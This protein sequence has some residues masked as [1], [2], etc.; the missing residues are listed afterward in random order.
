L[1][2]LP[3]PEHFPKNSFISENGDIIKLSNSH[4]VKYSRYSGKFYSLTTTRGCPFSCAYCCNSFYNKLYGKPIIR[5]RSVEN[6]IQEL[7][8]AI[9]KFPDFVYINIQ[10]DNFFTYDIDWMT[11]F[12]NRYKKE[13]G[14]NFVCRTNP[15]LLN[16]E[17]ISVLRMT[18][19]SWIFMGLQ[20]GSARI[21]KEIYKR[22]VSNKKFIEATKIIHKHNIAGYYDVI[23]DNPY[24][25]DRDL[26]RTVYLILRI[27]KPFMLQL[28]SLCF[29]QGTELYNRALKENLKFDNP[30]DK[31]F[32]AYKQTYLN[33]LVRLTPLYPMMFIRLMVKNRKS[34]FAKYLLRLI[35]YPSILI[36][37]PMVWFRLCYISFDKNI[38]F[39]VNMAKAFFKTAF[40]QRILR[41]N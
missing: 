40:D 23:L 18:G 27:P 21:N 36:I 24:E 30:L 39:T 2:A 19:L 37:E 34:G 28:F 35:Y 17:K 25:T 1:D 41:K 4:F 33:R 8:L 38:L 7:K 31:N 5:R 15:S 22:F 10:D 26:I 12:A 9:K 29:Y 32:V 16:E 14:K 3:F 6:V 20:S 11:D 13:I